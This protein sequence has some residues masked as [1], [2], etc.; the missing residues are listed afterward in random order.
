MTKKTGKHRARIRQA[1]FDFDRGR[2]G[3]WRPGAGRKRRGRGRVGHRRRP[4]VSR[5]RPLHLTLRM[6]KDVGHLRRRRAW[7]E[8]RTAFLHGHRKPGFRIC[9]F[10]IQHNHIH[11]LVEAHDNRALARGMQ[12]FNARVT[13]R[14]NRACGGRRGT[15]FADRYD[16]Q[17]LAS[18]R[19]ARAGLRYVLLNSRRH[20]VDLDELHGHVEW[21]AAWVDDYASWSYFDG[22]REGQPAGPPPG[23]PH[24]WLVA[25]PASWLLREGWQKHGLISV[26]EVPGTARPSR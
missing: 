10:S 2:H 17:V 12:G 18:P 3:G 22:W 4:R 26:T 5:H 25:R 7:K 9:H 6:V 23:E 13:K 11:L 8:L 16:L 21:R 24:E 14:I 19:Q 20:A 1:G 15:A